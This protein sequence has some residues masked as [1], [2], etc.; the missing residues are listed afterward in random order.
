MP[1]A[2]T[3][4]SIS[5]R[6]REANQSVKSVFFPFFSLFLF[7]KIHSNVSLINLRDITR[8]TK[9]GDWIVSWKKKKKRKRKRRAIFPS[10]TFREPFESL[11]QVRPMAGGPTIWP[12]RRLSAGDVINSLQPQQFVGTQSITG[13]QVI[14]YGGI[15]SICSAK[16]KT[17]RLT[18]S[19]FLQK[20]NTG[21]DSSRNDRSI[22]N[23][24][25]SLCVYIS[26]SDKCILEDPSINRN[27]EFLVVGK[28]P[29]KFV[30]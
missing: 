21:Q 28:E 22:N 13:D 24:N 23:K 3:R 6:A 9:V 18:I 30:C 27:T 10:K 26:I 5:L 16:V 7:F 11:V 19:N 29:R 4:S 15:G 8:P 1:R 17:G 2:D 20:T 25:V 14:A 12:T